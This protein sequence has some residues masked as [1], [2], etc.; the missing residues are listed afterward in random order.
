MMSSHATE[1]QIQGVLER[2]RSKGLD[3]HRSGGEER[4]VIGVIGTRFEPQLGEQLEMLSGVEKTTPIS[5]PYKLVSREFQP[6]DSVI[7][8]GGLKIGA[9]E[10]SV[11]AGPCAVESMEQM[12][13]TALAV[14]A[15]GARVLRGGAF[16]P[17]TSPY[18]FQGMGEEGLDI[19]AEV[20]QRTGLKIITEVMEP[21]QV[22]MVAAHADI[23]QIGARSMQ[24]FPLL[25]EVGR[26]AKPV[27]LK[28]GMAATID[29]WLMAAEY[30]MAAGN[31]NVILCERG[32]RTFETAV[33]NTLDLSAVP[34]AKRLSH[35]PVIVDPSHG[36]GKWYLVKPMAMAA[37]AAGADGVLI[38]VHPT[39]D[40]ATSDGPQSLTLPNFRELM[41]TLRVVGSAVG[42][43]LPLGAQGLAVE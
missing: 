18:A 27:L 29:E 23:L 4:T 15:A 24:N 34:V 9:G 16:K 6:F 35:L 41:D 21:E 5:K 10:L 38:E 3:G 19:L 11:M 37:V 17:R 25:R 31:F 1:P 36:T 2:L 42:R 40:T 8:V 7:N 33:R 22:D 43:Q 26:V 13:E 30:I 12:M 28:R 14:K 32:I 39:P 20:G